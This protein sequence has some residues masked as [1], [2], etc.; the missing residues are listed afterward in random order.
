MKTLS[1][2][3]NLV[4]FGSWWM[5]LHKRSCC[6]TW[7]PRKINLGFAKDSRKFFYSRRIAFPGRNF[8]QPSYSTYKYRY[9]YIFIYCI[10]LFFLIIY[11]LKIFE[12]Y[13]AFADFNSQSPS[14]HV[15]TSQGRGWHLG[16]RRLWA[17]P[18]RSLPVELPDQSRGFCTWMPIKERYLM[19]FYT[20]KHA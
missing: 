7:V 1:V 5:N 18:D 17:G 4:W 15:S 13:Y 19:I 9:I 3:I 12:D 10:Y 8:D 2:I 11:L 6:S 20:H 14:L 16:Q